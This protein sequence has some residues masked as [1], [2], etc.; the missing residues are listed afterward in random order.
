MTETTYIDEIIEETSRQEFDGFEESEPHQLPNHFR[1]LRKQHTHS[2]INTFHLKHPIIHVLLF[3]T[4]PSTTQ[5]NL[6]HA[7]RE[8]RRHAVRHEPAIAQPDHV[9]R[10]V[11]PVGLQQGNDALCLELFGS[12]GSGRVGV[13]EED[14][15]GNVDAEV[16]REWGDEWAPLPHC[17]GSDSVEENERRLGVGIGTLSF[18]DPAMH[19]GSV[20]EISGGWFEAGVGEGVAE[21][22][23]APGG[24]A[25]TSAT[26]THIDQL[27]LL[28]F[29]FPP[30]RVLELEWSKFLVKEN[31]MV[32]FWWMK[33]PSGEAYSCCRVED[34]DG[35]RSSLPNY[36]FSISL[37][38]FLCN[39]LFITSIFYKQMITNLN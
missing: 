39:Y 31:G 33:R 17:V 37:S 20:A 34:C 9:S 38:L 10:P 22:P 36:Y 7:Q 2:L 21:P 26:T 8:H 27:L 25:Q 32:G 28:L 6:P 14:Q 13:T 3:Q 24:E 35:R 19:Y 5:H 1:R 23:V 16:A 11:N 29:F 18:G 12:F 4:H 30:F 15:V